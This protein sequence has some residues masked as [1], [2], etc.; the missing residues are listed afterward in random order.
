MT[1]LRPKRRPTVLTILAPFR[2]RWNLDYGTEIGGICCLWDDNS[3]A[4]CCACQQLITTY[5]IALNLLYE[6]QVK[7]SFSTHLAGR[8]RVR[9][10]SDRQVQGLRSW[11]YA[12]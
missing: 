2:Y 12:F 4:V 6:R 7:P 5:C 11:L 9:A 3:T 10:R 8:R 1:H